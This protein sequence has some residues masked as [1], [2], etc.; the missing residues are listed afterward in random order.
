MKW[1]F[2]ALFLIA[3]ALWLGGAVATLLF[4]QRLFHNDRS[5]AVVV[6]PQLFL[7][8]EKYQLAL[9]AIVVVTLASRGRKRFP[10]LAALVLIAAITGTVSAIV[11]TPRI[12]NMRR[13]HEEGTDAFRTLHGLSMLVYLIEDVLL[14]AAG[15]LL[16]R[17][18]A[19]SQGHGR[20]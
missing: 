3:W 2:S 13:L 6:A 9:A 20:K 12:E 19:E 10:A 17:P 18:P 7:T 14:L 16:A 4:V 15:F 11:V 5:L 8:F 1:F